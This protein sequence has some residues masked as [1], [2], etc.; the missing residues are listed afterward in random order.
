MNG[1]LKYFKGDFLSE[2]GGSLSDL[3][4]FSLKLSFE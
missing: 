1:K 2:F 4:D 3:L